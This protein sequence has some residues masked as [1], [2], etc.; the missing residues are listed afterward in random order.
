MTALVTPANRK[1][2]A[3]V[4]S[5][6]QG[7]VKRDISAAARQELGEAIQS[8]RR[9]ELPLLAPLTLLKHHLTTHAD[10]YA[11]DQIYLAPHPHSAGLRR[12]L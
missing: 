8:Y 7:Y 12:E 2:H 9:G 10:Q 1:G 5:H 4:L 6:L 11:L 3:N